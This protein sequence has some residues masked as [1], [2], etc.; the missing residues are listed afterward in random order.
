VYQSL[1]KPFFQG[2]IFLLKGD[3]FPGQIEA[4][5]GEKGRNGRQH[6]KKFL[7]C[8]A[9]TDLEILERKG[10]GSFQDCRE[11]TK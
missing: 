9:E 7:V 5:K 6:R 4:T 3:N 10:R 11:M 8:F 1:P 2:E